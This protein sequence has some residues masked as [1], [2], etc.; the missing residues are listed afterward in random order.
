MAALDAL[1]R[2]RTVVVLTASP[3]EEHGPHLPLGVDAFTARYFAEALAE[4]LVKER[5]GWSAVLAPTLWLGSFTFDAVG[6]VNVR[7]RV[8]RDALVDYGDAL[9]RAGFRFILVSNGHAGPT[10]LTAL[11][12]ASQI[13]SRRHGVTMASLSGHLAW[14]F[15]NGRFLQD[16]ERA[17]G[18]ALTDDEHRAFTEDA[19]AGWWETSMMLMLRP[20]LVH[21][22]WRTLPS[23]TYPMA[24]RVVPNYPLRGG[25]QGYVGHPAMGDPVFAKATSEALL[26]A[27]LELVDELIDGTL[28]PSDRRSPFFAVPF[29]RT[30]FWRAAA[31]AGAF[32]AG[33]ALTALTLG[34]RKKNSGQ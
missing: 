23:A 19:H 22:A 21:E 34:R 31:G 10:H 33:V 24:A 28:R 12:E 14:G 7:Q 16:V 17:L 2:A 11:D 25:G 8:V 4:R 26:G 15:R 18:R 32:A 9:A 6:T 20:D 5:P 13:V 30:N 29:F 27:T 1:D 3:L